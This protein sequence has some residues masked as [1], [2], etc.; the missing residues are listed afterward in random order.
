M[1]NKRAL[2]IA[3]IL[4]AALA[5]VVPGLSTPAAVPP[6]PTDD[7][8]LLTMVVETVAAAMLQTAQAVTSTP[9]PTFTPAPTAAPSATP[10]PGS[11][12]L[13]QEDASTLFTDERAGYSIAIPAGWLVA[14]INQPE[15]FDALTLAELSDPL[16]YEALAKVQN[17]DPRVLR[18]FAV[19]TQDETV[20]DEPV[21]TIKFIWNEKKDVS[22]NSIQDLQALADELTK[23]EQGLEVTAIDIVTSLTHTQ[24]G[25]IES[26]TKGS[27]GVL[28]IQKRVFFKVKIGSIYAL[29]TTGQSLKENIIPA[30]D[31]MMDT[32]K[33]RE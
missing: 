22:F 33:L 32:V 10:P 11:S 6:A 8:R 7:G 3:V 4:T 21:T 30:F 12:L 28:I 20:Q 5:C 27:A 15:F 14:R 9:A 13:K 2:L 25:V 18:L 17:E 19:D 26:E 1:N 24:F 29:L 16:I 23:T 31:A